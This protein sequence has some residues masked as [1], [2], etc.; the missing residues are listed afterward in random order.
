VKNAVVTTIKVIGVIVVIAA[1]IIAVR[2]LNTQLNYNSN[3]DIFGIGSSIF[4]G[5][6]ISAAIIAGSGVLVY[7]FGEIIQLLQGIED[8]T[9]YIDYGVS[10]LEEIRDNTYLSKDEGNNSEEKK[11]Q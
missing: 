8:N 5:G 6:Y 2:T 9:R 3:A 11:R 10:L 4:S 1:I 7:G